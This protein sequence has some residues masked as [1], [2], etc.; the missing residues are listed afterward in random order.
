MD[1]ERLMEQLAKADGLVLRGE[2][3]IARQRAM[4]ADREQQG[5]SVAL[6]R[7]VLELF[8]A[9]QEQFTVYRDR[10]QRALAQKT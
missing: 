5:R 7:R 1:R 6:E 8:E 2:R 4:I 3:N 9:S 10:L